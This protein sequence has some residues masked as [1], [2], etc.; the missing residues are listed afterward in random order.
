[1]S[2]CTRYQR[3]EQQA[4]TSLNNGFL[5]ILQNLDRYRGDEVPFEAWIRRIMINTAIDAFRREKKWRELTVF[6]GTIEKDYPDERLDFN[7]GDERLNAQYLEAL[8][9]RLPPVTQ[10]VFNMFALDGFSHREISELMGMSE[11][12]SKWHVSHARS[13]LQNW[14][15]TEFNP[16]L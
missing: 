3:D 8:L 2:V 16:A 15:K 11:G 9:R 6:T 7:E 12:T 1:M 13:Q 14:I 10:Q 4:V 5:K